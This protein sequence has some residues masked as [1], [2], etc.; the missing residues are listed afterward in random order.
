M[1][2]FDVFVMMM[3]VGARCSV[4][5]L[6]AVQTHLGIHLHKHQQLTHPQPQ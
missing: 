3:Y 1:P 5:G 4:L 6:G 2:M